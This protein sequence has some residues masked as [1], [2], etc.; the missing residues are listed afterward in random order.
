LITSA[1]ARIFPDYRSVLLVCYE[2]E[3]SGEGYFA[4]MARQFSGRQRDA[5]LMIVRMEQIP[6]RVLHALIVRHGIAANDAATLYAEGEAE[7]ARSKGMSWDALT[8]SMAD[9]YPVYKKEF[10]QLERLAP[11]EDRAPVAIAAEHER[12]L[13]EFGRREVSGDP[14]SIEKLKQFLARYGGDSAG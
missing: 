11:A 3:V 5:L 9:E 14:R 2:E 13:I 6:A 10:D 1:A 4:G 12:V 8:R 7:A